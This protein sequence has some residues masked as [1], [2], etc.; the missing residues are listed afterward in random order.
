VVTHVSIPPSRYSIHKIIYHR[1]ASLGRQKEICYYAWLKGRQTFFC[2]LQKKLC[3]SLNKQ[4]FNYANVMLSL[5]S[6]PQSLVFLAGVFSLF[7]IIP[8]LD[9]C[10]SFL[11][12]FFSKA[13]LFQS[14]NLFTIDYQA[15]IRVINQ[16][17][18]SKC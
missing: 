13:F 7:G 8:C 14:S 11:F 2:S 3:L 18:C 16:L 1:V 15:S 10:N 4:I 17:K 9:Y 12:F 5:D 6:P